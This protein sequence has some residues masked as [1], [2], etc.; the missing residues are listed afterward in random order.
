MSTTKTGFISGK[1]PCAQ[2]PVQLGL[3]PCCWCCPGEVLASEAMHVTLA[4]IGQLSDASSG[5]Q[6]VGPGEDKGEDS[7]ADTIN[8]RGGTTQKFGESED[9]EDKAWLLCDAS[10]APSGSGASDDSDATMRGV[11][12]GDWESDTDTSSQT[13]MGL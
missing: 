2:S 12:Y 13:S 8:M 6:G 3:T 10:A 7:G 11:G 4:S 1:F 9:S 5:G